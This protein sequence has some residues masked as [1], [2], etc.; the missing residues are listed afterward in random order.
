MLGQAVPHRVESRT[1]A[2]VDADHVMSGEEEMDLDDGRSLVTVRRPVGH[3]VGVV[4]VIL[5][6]RALVEFAGTGEGQG[7]DPEGVAEHGLELV[8]DFVDVEPE[9]LLG[10]ESLGHLL[11]SRRSTRAVRGED[12]VHRI[13]SAAVRRG[14]RGPAQSGRS[15]RTRSSRKRCPLATYS[16]A[17]IRIISHCEAPGRILA[18][19]PTAKAPL[20]HGHAIGHDGVGS[21]RRP[22]AD[23]GVVED[24]GARPDEAFVL[25]LTALEMGE[26][27]DDTAVADRRG[28]TRAG[29]DYRSRPAPTSAPRW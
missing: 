1:L 16:A 12:R 10:P 2:V 27:A 4:V 29:M 7:V 17:A 18:G 15:M 26:M 21:N 25:Q 20:G 3:H 14:K 23:H 19:T 9:E 13:E 11:G 5:N 22:R 28:K 8:V 6:L 24:D